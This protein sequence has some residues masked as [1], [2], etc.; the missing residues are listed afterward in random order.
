M[1]WWHQT[2]IPTA[3]TLWLLTSGVAVALF[4]G[5]KG[6]L[7]LDLLILVTCSLDYI[8]ALRAGAIDAERRCP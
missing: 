7:A 3:R 2:P 6:A 1:K 5:W 4:W 8:M